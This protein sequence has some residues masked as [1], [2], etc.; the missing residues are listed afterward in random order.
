[1][2]SS[3]CRPGGERARWIRTERLIDQ[4][5]SPSLADPIALARR[6]AVTEVVFAYGDVS[7]AHVTRVGSRALA[8]GADFV[9]PG[10]ERTMLR[11]GVPV[12]AVSA[13]RTG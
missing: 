12:V 7:D 11:A 9:L 3:P 2:T 6:E 8:A 4:R 1:M 5:V 13:V 10:P